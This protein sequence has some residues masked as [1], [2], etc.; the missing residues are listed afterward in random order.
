MI[1]YFQWFR[2]LARLVAN[3]YACEVAA[4]YS[5]LDADTVNRLT[6]H[7]VPELQEFLRNSA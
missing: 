3:V 2:T 4:S 6:V 1:A 5:T 7:A